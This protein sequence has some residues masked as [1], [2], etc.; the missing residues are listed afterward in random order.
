ILAFLV[1]NLQWATVGTHH[2][3]LQLSVAAIELRVGWMVCQHV[4]IA[5]VTADVVKDLRQLT[6]KT[7]KVGASTSQSGEGIHFVICLKIVHLPD[8]DSDTVRI[9]ATVRFAILPHRKSNADRENGY[10]LGR[11]DLFED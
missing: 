4:L 6:L 11:F 7:G 5:N 1:S 3:D 9:A 2:V 8:W 10:I